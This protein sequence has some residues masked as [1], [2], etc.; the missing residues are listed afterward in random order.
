VKEPAMAEHKTVV[1]GSVAE[2]EQALRDAAIA[3]G[4]HEEQLGRYD[5]NWPSWYAQYMANAA[6]PVDNG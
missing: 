5:E 1:Y 2:L 6:T 3:H 4:K